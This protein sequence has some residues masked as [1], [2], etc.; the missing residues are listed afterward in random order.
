MSLNSPQRLALSVVDNQGFWEPDVLG[1]ES[2]KP[3][4]TVLLETD[5]SEGLF[6]DLQTETASVT[7]PVMVEMT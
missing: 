6:P 5:L 7:C 1:Y 3:Q 4:Y 2:P